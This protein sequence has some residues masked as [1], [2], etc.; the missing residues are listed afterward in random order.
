MHE[1]Q[2][3]GNRE[4]PPAPRPWYSHVTE[5]RLIDTGVYTLAFGGFYIGYSTLRHVALNNGFPTSQA[6]V[7]AALAD[8]AIL[9]YSWKAKQEVEQGR[10]AWGIRG[11]V[12]LM[13][14]ATFYLQMRAAWPDPTAT[15][16]HALAPVC[17]IVGHEMMLRGKLRDAKRAL[18]QAQIDAGIRPAP[19]AKLRTTE[20][21]LS[22]LRTLKVWRRMVL[23]SVPADVVKRTLAAERRAANK[24]VPAAWAGVLLDDE[25]EPTPAEEPAPAPASEPVFDSAVKLTAGGT[26]TDTQV[27]AFVNALPPVP[28]EGR[29]KQEARAWVDHVEAIADQHGIDCTNVMLAKLLGVSGGYIT[30]IKKPLLMAVTSP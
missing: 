23:W 26:A 28:A 4:N 14:L 29:S 19:L 16:M 13:S 22:P 9:V 24:P 2:S 10:S 11:I 20:W 17:W 25:A 27:D 12:I 15:A 6:V 30:A 21:I 7:V 8:L 3:N 18:K 5:A 1:N